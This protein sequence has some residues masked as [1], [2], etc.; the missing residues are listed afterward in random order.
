MPKQIS[1]VAGGE[2]SS[3]N[4][5]TSTFHYGA[6]HQRVKQIKTGAQ[7][8]STIYYAGA[9]EVELS[10]N[11]Q[12]LITL[13]T[14][15]PGGLGV[16]ID[17]PSTGTDT[18]NTSTTK[19]EQLWTHQD[20]LGSPIAIS[21]SAGVL[22][23]RLAYDS[24]GK[25]RSLAG[26]ETL[27]SIDGKLDNKG[28]TGHEML[29]QLDLVHMNGRIYD[30]QIARF[31]SAD[32][33]IQDPTHSQSYNRYTYVWNNPTN[34]TDPSGFQARGNG[35]KA[36]PT[37]GDKH[38]NGS[39]NNCEDNPGHSKCKP[40]ANEQVTSSSKDTTGKPGAE[41]ED[42]TNGGSAAANAPSCNDKGCWETKELNALREKKDV[43]G[44]Y[45]SACKGG[46]AYACNARRIAANDNSTTGLTGLL[47]P[48]TNVRLSEASLE[49]LKSPTRDELIRAIEAPERIKMELM[50]GY[51]EYLSK[52]S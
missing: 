46:N 16:D 4:T 31:M 47:T 23:E 51:G 36:I 38:S 35:L 14:Y 25:R 45:D 26:N 7:G 29:D 22:V 21:N 15:W 3:A 40:K 12:A 24:W 11:T 17:K 18:G 48:L 27:D 9:M 49:P 8:N 1:K 2:G 13:K 39:W 28:F 6:D 42:A 5:E 41:A 33:I 19:T 32:P 43:L 50:Q 34:L 44:Y 20:R 52:G 30:P 37:P 10:S